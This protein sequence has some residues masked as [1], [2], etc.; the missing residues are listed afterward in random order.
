MAKAIDAHITFHKKEMHE[1]ALSQSQIKQSITEIE[2]S[3]IEQIFRRAARYN[4]SFKS[5]LSSLRE[6]IPIP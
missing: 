2:D 4:S 6:Q 3:L 5:N 1:A